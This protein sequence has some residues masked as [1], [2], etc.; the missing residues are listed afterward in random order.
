MEDEGTA[1]VVKSGYKPGAQRELKAYTILVVLPADE[2]LKTFQ[3]ILKHKD[4]IART[5][6]SEQSKGA[7]EMLL[8]VQT[9][10]FGDF[11]AGDKADTYDFVGLAYLHQFTK[12]ELDKQLEY[13]RYYTQ[14]PVVHVFLGKAVARDRAALSSS[15][16]FLMDQFENR[17]GAEEPTYLPTDTAE[18]VAA[19]ILAVKQLARTYEAKKEEEVKKAFE[20]FDKN[21]NGAID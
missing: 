11:Q 18:A 2:D 13:L 9:T 7:Q 8:T 4:F 12:D 19:F 6:G 10:T 1:P 3:E 20:K 16:S 21:G 17:L 15:F 5:Q 14:V